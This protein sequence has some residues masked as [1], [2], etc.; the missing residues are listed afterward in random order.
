[1]KVSKDSVLIGVPIA[2]LKAYLPND[3]LIC[4]IESKGAL[5]IGKGD[6]IL[7]P[8]DNVILLTTPR[9]IHELEHLF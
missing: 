6:R 4:V 3:L 2:D 9:S 7:S 5:M 8:G 1:M